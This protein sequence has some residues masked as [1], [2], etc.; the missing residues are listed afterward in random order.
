MD[1]L[2]LCE[3]FLSDSTLKLVNIPGYKL[4]SDHRK[5]HKDGGTTILVRNDIVSKR[6]TDLMAFYEKEIEST[7][8]EIQTKRVVKQL[9]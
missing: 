5:H 3:T 6:R 7:F 1:L 8:I 2:L 4:Y 9:L